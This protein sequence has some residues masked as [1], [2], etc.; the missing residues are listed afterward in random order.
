MRVLSYIGID[1]MSF[2]IIGMK[3]RCQIKKLPHPVPL[4]RMGK[5]ITEAERSAAIQMGW[6]RGLNAHPLA[7]CWLLM[8]AARR[9]WTGGRAF[10]PEVLPKVGVSPDRHQRPR[11]YPSFRLAMRQIQDQGVVGIEQPDDMAQ[12]YVC[13]TL[14][15]CG[16]PG[17][18]LDELAASTLGIDFGSWEDLCQITPEEVAFIPFPSIRLQALGKD[19]QSA[20]S[21]AWA[22]RDLARVMVD[23][24]ASL[25]LLHRMPNVQA[26]PNAAPASRTAAPVRI[27]LFD[28]GIHVEVDFAHRRP[29][30]RAILRWE[31]KAFLG[32]RP[33]GEWEVKPGWD[34]YW[35]SPPL[36]C[37]DRIEI[38]RPVD[39]GSQKR[40]LPGIL[41]A[42]VD[43]GQPLSQVESGLAVRVLM[44]R[45]TSVQGLNRHGAGPVPGW[46]DHQL[47]MGSVGEGGLRVDAQVFAIR[48]ASTV[49]PVRWSGT[50]IDL[51]HRH[52]RLTVAPGK[53]ALNSPDL[54]AIETPAGR[55]T[56]DQ[57]LWE[58]ELAPDDRLRVRPIR[59]DGPGAPVLIEARLPVWHPVQ[60]I[61]RLVS[62]TP[63]PTRQL[64]PGQETRVS[65]D[66]AADLVPSL[67]GLSL[68][69]PGGQRI[70]WEAPIPAERVRRLLERH[71]RLVIRQGLL[72]LHTLRRRRWWVLDDIVTEGDCISF[73]IAERGEGS[74]QLAMMSLDGHSLDPVAGL[75]QGDRMTW[76]IPVPE[77]PAFWVLIGPDGPALERWN[78]GKA[79]A[80]RCLPTPADWKRQAETRW[81]HP[82]VDEAN[83]LSKMTMA[84]RLAA[85]RRTDWPQDLMYLTDMTAVQYVEAQIKQ[86]VK[87]W[88][89]DHEDQADALVLGAHAAVYPVAI[90]A[91]D[92]TGIY[93]RPL[94]VRPGNLEAGRILTGW[95]PDTWGWLTESILAGSDPDAVCCVLDLPEMQQ[96]AA[97]PSE[98]RR[99]ILLAAGWLVQQGGND[100]RLAVLEP[101]DQYGPEAL[102]LAVIMALKSD[103]VLGQSLAQADPWPIPDWAAR[104]AD[105][106]GTIHPVL[107]RAVRVAIRQL[108]S[109]PLDQHERVVVK[110]AINPDLYPLVRWC[111]R[112]LRHLEPA[113]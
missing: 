68:H 17:A 29:D 73:R 35:M 113:P 54:V 47:L 85:F 76:S 51:R 81:V 20:T 63:S 7:A 38:C 100:F 48:A 2:A 111:G 33:V 9:H 6:E 12:P 80:L 3:L 104:F 66:E 52:L 91:L 50:P 98:Q 26:A 49:Q 96:L 31:L 18:W 67:K 15:Q 62:P 83:L 70:L 13:W 11:F 22:I 69:L 8:D 65:L 110:E 21:I 44:P 30:E 40:L 95:D 36:P 103:L 102:I 46:P 58:K 25:E 16:L 74:L 55:E 99:A 78:N 109:R 19:P 53:L 112:R 28:D 93:W 60:A 43:T 56:A 75:E 88:R 87:W 59:T 79:L 24:H 86:Q 32:T 57:G 37:C 106:V 71:E 1:N 72:P 108:D 105:T 84:A 10:W 39:G 42:D 94:P 14:A 77:S 107:K 34:S 89:E 4:G 82:P 61:G 101:E 64:R 23:P 90:E 97:M 45:Q 92:P 5:E 41:V 27:R